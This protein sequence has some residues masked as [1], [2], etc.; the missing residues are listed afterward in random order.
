PVLL[1][2]FI[3]ACAAPASRPVQGISREEL[4]EHVLLFGSIWNPYAGRKYGDVV[5]GESAEGE[6]IR[7]AGDAEMRA[8][9][10]SKGSVMLFSQLVTPG[11]YRINRSGNPR[12]T[13]WSQPV[14]FEAGEIVYMGQFLCIPL[15]S[16]CLW[17][18][19][20]QLGRDIYYASEAA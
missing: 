15:W 8:S 10:N 3:V 11:E 13:W 16:G 17:V 9:E 18:S 14:R 6:S 20:D 12:T 4:K 19:F 7:M 2:P 1:L 5:Y